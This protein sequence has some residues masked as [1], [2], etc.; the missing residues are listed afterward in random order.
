MIDVVCE[1]GKYRGNLNGARKGMKGKMPLAVSR[2]DSAGQR[3]CLQDEGTVQHGPKHFPDRF[4]REISVVKELLLYEGEL[5]FQVFLSEKGIFLAFYGLG[6][7]LV[8]G[9]ISVKI[10]HIQF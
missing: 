1:K 3:L 7:Q 4:P 9:L 2:T 6:E 8:D 10:A 5:L